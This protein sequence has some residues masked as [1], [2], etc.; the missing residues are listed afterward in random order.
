MRKKLTTKDKIIP[1]SL[2]R[3]LKEL[4]SNTRRS[5][6]SKSDLFGPLNL[7]NSMIDS[8][9]ITFEKDQIVH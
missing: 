6:K 8:K 4:D 3:I 5:S 2:Q 9:A 1:Y 7:I